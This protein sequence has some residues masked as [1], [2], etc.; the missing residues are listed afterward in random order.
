VKEAL[1]QM[2]I[3]NQWG[4]WKQADT[5][6]AK[7]VKDL[8]LNDDFW[9]RVEYVLEFTEPIMSMLRFA[10]TDEPCLGDI[11]DA[12]DSMLERVKMV[13]LDFYTILYPCLLRDFDY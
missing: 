12:M 11:Y 7:N 4:G 1:C 2:V 9:S 3:S 10:D 13:S 8:I 6:R 5:G